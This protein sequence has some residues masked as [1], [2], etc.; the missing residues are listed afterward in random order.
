MCPVYTVKVSLQCR[1]VCLYIKIEFP[2]YSVIVNILALIIMAVAQVANHTDS[3]NF[4]LHSE[5]M[6]QQYVITV[7]Y[8]H[9]KSWSIR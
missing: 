5:T 2:Y 6:I 9:T 7:T 1:R 3:A 8:T 4:V